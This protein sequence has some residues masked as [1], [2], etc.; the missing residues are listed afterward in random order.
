MYTIELL[1]KSNI[2][3]I[4]HSLVEKVV[5]ARDDQNNEQTSVLR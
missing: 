1:E 5:P 4:A 2:F 3:N